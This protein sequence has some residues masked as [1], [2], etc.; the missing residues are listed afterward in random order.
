MANRAAAGVKPAGAKQHSAR[1]QYIGEAVTELKK[2]IWLSRQETAYLTV[3]VVIVSVAVGVLLGGLDYG[4]ANLINKLL[5]G[6]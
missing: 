6:R 1:F 4:F 5:L 3:M 2:V